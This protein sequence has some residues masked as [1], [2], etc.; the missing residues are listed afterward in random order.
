MNAQYSYRITED[1]VVARLDNGPN[2]NLG[3]LIITIT[4]I[5]AIMHVHVR[6]TCNYNL[7]GI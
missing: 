6:D 1:S 4:I 2:V 7:L 3:K 5:I